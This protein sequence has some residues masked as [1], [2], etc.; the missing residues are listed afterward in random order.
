MNCLKGIPTEDLIFGNKRI[1]A[2]VYEADFL[3]TDKNNQLIIEDV[4]GCETAT[5]RLKW[6][7]LQYIF[8]GLSTIEFRKVK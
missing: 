5:F 8:R 3:Y 1:R 4:K 7:M 6:K 2:I